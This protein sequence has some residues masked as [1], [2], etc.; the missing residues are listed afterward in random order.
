MQLVPRSAWTDALQN[1]R[2]KSKVVEEL[3]LAMKVFGIFS[4][5]AAEKEF[6]LHQKVVQLESSVTKSHMLK[7][8]L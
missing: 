1:I 6:R 5:Y 3:S 2:E 8:T 4:E 7:F